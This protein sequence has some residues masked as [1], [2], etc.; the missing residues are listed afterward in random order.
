MVGSYGCDPELDCAPPCIDSLRFQIPGVVHLFTPHSAFAAVVCQGDVCWVATFEVPIPGESCSTAYDDGVLCCQVSWPTEGLDD[1]CRTEGDDL[2]I[3]LPLDA[4]TTAE[5]G[6]VSVIDS[7]GDEL[8]Y[9]AAIAISPHQAAGA[10]S[11]GCLRTA[12]SL[13]ER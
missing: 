6:T 8:L 11:C 10:D 1:V 13:P 5:P 9:S 4:P 2:V 12:L 3:E 7:E